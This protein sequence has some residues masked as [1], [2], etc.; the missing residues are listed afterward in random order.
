[1]TNQQTTTVPKHRCPGLCARVL[2]TPA[3]VELTDAVNRTVRGL[4]VRCPNT[5]T[6]TC[7]SGAGCPAC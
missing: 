2:V 6:D 3:D 5:G 4:A 7:D 1:M